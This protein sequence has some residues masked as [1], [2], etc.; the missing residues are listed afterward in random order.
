MVA[1]NLI[2]ILNPLPVLWTKRIVSRF[3]LT[4]WM[5][6]KNEKRIR[7]NLSGGFKVWRK[8]YSCRLIDAE[9]VGWE[10]YSQDQSSDH[11]N[12]RHLFQYFWNSFIMFFNIIFPCNH[13]S[14]WDRCS[15]EE[16]EVFSCF[17]CRFGALFGLYFDFYF[18][19]SQWKP[20][21]ERF[22]LSG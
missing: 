11:L 13:C 5:Y 2:I 3:R 8:T 1:L 12:F 20:C 17:Y 16:L 18:W 10:S 4:K 19:C 14:L 21:F 15:F 22:F 7:P 6:L 9:P